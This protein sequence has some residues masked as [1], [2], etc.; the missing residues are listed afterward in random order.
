MVYPALLAADAPMRKTIL[1]LLRR[2]RLLE[3]VDEGAQRVLETQSGE[4]VRAIDHAHSH[5][6]VEKHGQAQRL[7]ASRKT[8][9]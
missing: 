2:E 1:R 5:D 6:V 8:A 9:G 4:F 3:A 7:F